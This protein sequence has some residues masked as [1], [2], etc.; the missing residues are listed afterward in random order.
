MIRQSTTQQSAIA[1]EM[2][3]SSLRPRHGFTITE[4]IVVIAIIGVLAA[5][6]IPVMSKGRANAKSIECMNNLRRWGQ[7]IHFYAMDNNGNYAVR[8][9]PDEAGVASSWPN[10]TNSPYINYFDGSTPGERLNHLREARRCPACDLTGPA[11]STTYVMNRAHFR[12]KT[13]NSDPPEQWA[14]PLHRASSPSRFLLMM[15]APRNGGQRLRGFEAFQSWSEPTE[16]EGERTIPELASAPFARHPGG[17]N[18]LFADG[19]VRKIHWEPRAPGDPDSAVA[20]QHVWFVL[21]PEN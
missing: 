17:I 18:A 9:E 10:G 11:G 20:Q 3:F 14:I 7:I 8:S 2:R 4:L 1:S 21:D 19:H 15:D 13:A 16:P 5:I 6:L 12:G